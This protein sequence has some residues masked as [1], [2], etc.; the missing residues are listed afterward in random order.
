MKQNKQVLNLSDFTK[1]DHPFGNVQGKETFRKLSDYI[2]AHPQIQIFGISLAGI[3]ATDASFPRESV[4]SVAKRYRESKGIYLEQIQD[5]DIL[6]NW[7]YAARAMEQPLVVW[8]NGKYEVLGPEVTLAGK[9]LID[10][11]LTKG[12]VL[13]SEVAADLDI[14]V[15][16]AST[17]L[18]KLVSQGYILRTEDVAETGGIEYVYLAI[19]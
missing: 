19:K 9:E 16:N 7:N 12:A 4:I 13:A 14:T 15:Q 2:D 1:D 11:V 8:S 10:Y 17:R 18:K 3:A 6:D 5:R